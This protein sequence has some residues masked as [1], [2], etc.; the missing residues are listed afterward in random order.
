MIISINLIGNIDWILAQLGK[1][2]L[3]ELVSKNYADPSLFTS[4]LPFDIQSLFP[5]FPSFETL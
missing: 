2:F 3:F 5:L 1:L 4:K